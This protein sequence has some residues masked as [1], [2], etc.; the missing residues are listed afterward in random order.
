M[1]CRANGHSCVARQQQEVGG[2]W[3]SSHSSIRQSPSEQI[4][5]GEKSGGGRER[6]WRSRGGRGGGK[7]SGGEE[8]EPP[9]PVLSQVLTKSE[10]KL[11]F[12]SPDTPAPPTHAKNN[13]PQRR[14]L[15]RSDR[16]TAE[17]IIEETI[18]TRNTDG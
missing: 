1:F 9:P 13:L 12:L 16:A 17:S 8:E 7:E 4:G 2:Q 5:G 3:K 15:R 18:F 14:V 6:E 10:I 11:F